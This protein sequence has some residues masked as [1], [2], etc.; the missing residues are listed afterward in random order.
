[1]SALAGSLSAAPIAHADDTDE[2]FLSSIGSVGITYSSPEN[3]VQAGHLVCGLLD[4]GKAKVDIARSIVGKDFGGNPMDAWHAGY[5][6]G[7]GVAAYC[8]QYRG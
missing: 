7:A 1:M 4:R 3:A 2:A 8:P 5:F 6:V